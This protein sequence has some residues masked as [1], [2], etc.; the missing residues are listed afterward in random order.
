MA[1]RSAGVCRQSL[2]AAWNRASG[3]LAQVMSVARKDAESKQQADFFNSHSDL[4]KAVAKIDSLIDATERA[5]DMLAEYPKV[6]FDNPYASYGLVGSSNCYKNA[7]LEISKIVDDLDIKVNEGI[8]AREAANKLRGISEDREEAIANAAGDQAGGLTGVGAGESENN[9]SDVTGVREDAAKQGN[10]TGARGIEK[11]DPDAVIG[12]DPEEA[13]AMKGPGK[14]GKN[15]ASDITSHENPNLAV[16]KFRNPGIGSKLDPSGRFSSRGTLGLAPALSGTADG[17][18]SGDKA[19][20]ADSL[21]EPEGKD[22][23][24]VKFGL[25]AE[26]PEKGLAN[27]DGPGL[28]ASARFPS[29]TQSDA[30][31]APQSSD[32]FQLVKNRYRQTELFRNACK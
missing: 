17:K 4:Q 14:A 29:A 32:L 7:F 25:D 30:F 9:L 8:A 24:K 13:E 12:L 27:A 15:S 18:K 3:E 11:F 26:V 20:V 10:L 16:E 28:D 2:I 19:S 1:S 22:G 5:A 21:F 23:D 6:M 31:A